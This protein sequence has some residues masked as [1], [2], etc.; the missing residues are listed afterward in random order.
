MN[1]KFKIIL[2]LL[3]DDKVKY[4]SI[5]ILFIYLIIKCLEG[6]GLQFIKREI[7]SM[8]DYIDPLVNF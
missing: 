6:I 4:T 3:I 2:Y 7:I 8:L 5:I 1:K